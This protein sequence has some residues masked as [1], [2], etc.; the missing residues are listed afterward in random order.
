MRLSGEAKLLRIFIGEK[1]RVGHKPLFEVIVQK[2]RELGL[3]GCTVLRAVEGF[4]AGSVIHKAKLLELSED[5]PFVL[6][7]VDSEDRINDFITVVDQLFEQAQ[8]GGLVTMERVQILK[9]SH[10]LKK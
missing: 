6:E 2:A 10:P 7:I 8:C 9:Y 1:D 3:A 5:L 4:G